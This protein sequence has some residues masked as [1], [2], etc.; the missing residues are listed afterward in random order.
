[1][2]TIDQFIK[3][4]NGTVAALWKDGAPVGVAIRKTFSGAEEVE[5]SISD[6]SGKGKDAIGQFLGELDS[7]IEIL[8]PE[9]SDVIFTKND[10]LIDEATEAEIQDWLFEQEVGTIIFEG[11]SDTD[12]ADF[13]V[14]LKLSENNW[15]TTACDFH[16]TED[17]AKALVGYEVH[18]L[19]TVIPFSG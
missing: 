8:H 17:A 15:T 12:S 3:S 5:T 10:G 13:S 7:R 4:P 19:P 2:T 6:W 11:R 1:M 9:G 16:P 18:I 14:G